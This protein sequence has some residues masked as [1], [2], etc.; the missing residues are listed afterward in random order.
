MTRRC[1]TQSIFLKSGGDSDEDDFDMRGRANGGGGRK[2]GHDG[3]CT[4]SLVAVTGYDQ[5]DDRCGPRKVDDDY[6]GS[7]GGA[8]S[9]R[10]PNAKVRGI[11]SMGMYSD[12]MGSEDDVVMMT[13]DDRQQSDGRQFQ[14]PNLRARKGGYWSNNRSPGGKGS[15]KGKGRS[16]GFR[17]ATMSP[18][19]VVKVIL[20]P[21]SGGGGSRKGGKGREGRQQT[22]WK[23]NYLAR[24]REQYL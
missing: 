22:F 17:Q 20:K 13:R 16:G 12:R 9:R 6:E 7:P 21:N 14:S 1:D 10:V 19:G 15:G 18:S 23:V 24:A 2:G 3:V 11:T 8:E 5:H 4:S